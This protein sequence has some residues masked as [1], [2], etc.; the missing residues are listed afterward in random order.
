MVYRLH[1]SNLVLNQ[2]MKH[3]CDLNDL[4]KVHI[5]HVVHYNLLKGQSL[6][7]FVRMMTY[8]VKD[9]R[10]EHYNQQLYLAW[11]L[12]GTY[13]IFLKQIFAAKSFLGCLYWHITKKLK[14]KTL[15][16]LVRVKIWFYIDIWVI[17]IWLR[18]LFILEAIFMI[19]LGLGT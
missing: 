13:N 5:D 10:K 8:C 2:V 15:V 1:I 6:H 17:N 7:T 16:S 4:L 3:Q 12:F 11:K 9:T 19:G 14:R 18:V